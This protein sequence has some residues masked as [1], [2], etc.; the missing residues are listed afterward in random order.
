MFLTCYQ[1]ETTYIVL[2]NMFKINLFSSLADFTDYFLYLLPQ[3]LGYI[4]GLN[5]VEI[6]DVIGR[7][8]VRDDGTMV[9]RFVWACAHACVMC[10]VY[11]IIL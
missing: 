10:Y 1:L 5:R 2:Y 7:E 11:M 8:I 4:Q 3:A 6:P 9:Q